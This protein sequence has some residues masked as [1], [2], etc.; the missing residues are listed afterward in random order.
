VCARCGAAAERPHAVSQGWWTFELC[1]RKHVRQFHQEK[2]VV[3][4]EYVLGRFDEGATAQLHAQ[5]GQPYSEEATPTG[6]ATRCARAPAC[7][8]LRPLRAGCSRAHAAPRSFHAHVFANGTACDLTAE[9]RST[10][11]RFVCAPEAGAAVAAGA[12]AAHFI[13]S[14]K[15]P[16]TCHYVL[17]LATPLL[18]AHA[19]FRV[20]E[21]PVAHIRCRATAPPAAQDGARE[22]GEQHARA[23]GAA[24]LA[25]GGHAGG[26]PDAARDEL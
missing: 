9:P 1:V 14:V 17:T 7:A 12:A 24:G 8:R 22:G 23:G 21:A 26:A 3:V 19:A 13:E 11:V 10:E 5:A 6:A 15:E 16:V 25:Q 20:E 4:S 2:D 18:C